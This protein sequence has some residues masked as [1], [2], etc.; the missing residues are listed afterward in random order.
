M[1]EVVLFPRSKPQGLRLNW[2]K[3][4]R[5]WSGQHDNM[6]AHQ[7]FGVSLH[8]AK[9]FGSINHEL[10]VSPGVL[11][12]PSPKSQTLKPKTPKP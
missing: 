6:R 8:Y 10:V 3:L 5:A 1:I 2:A 7:S 4:G 9:A 11:E 12:A